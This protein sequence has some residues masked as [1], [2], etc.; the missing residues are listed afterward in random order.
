MMKRPK[1]YAYK[2]LNFSF[3]EDLKKKSTIKKK[4]KKM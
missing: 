4:F 2:Q 1:S 3:H